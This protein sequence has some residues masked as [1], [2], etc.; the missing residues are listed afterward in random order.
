GGDALAAAGLADQ[1]E[2]LAFA[3]L[4]RR[5]VDRE[6]R[7]VLGAEPD[8]QVG[9]RQQRGGGDAGHRRLSLGSSAS[10][11][12][13][14]SRLSASASS[15][16]ATPGNTAIHGASRNSGCALASMTPND[17]VGGRMPSPRKEST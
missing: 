2:H 4:E 5:L 15:T 10:R 7:T 16:M 8:G 6:H 1:R 12:P 17:G 13:S 11:M 9:D 14:P 3:D